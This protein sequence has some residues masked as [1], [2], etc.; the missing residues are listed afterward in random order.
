[1]VVDGHSLTLEIVAIPDEGTQVS[2][3]LE[4][5]LGDLDPALE[6]LQPDLVFRLDPS[7]VALECTHSGLHPVNLC[8]PP[9][10]VISSKPL[11]ED[12]ASVNTANPRPDP[13]SPA[14]TARKG[15]NRGDECL[16]PPRHVT[17][18]SRDSQSHIRAALLLARPLWPWSYVV[19]YLPRDQ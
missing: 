4:E 8:G 17:H 14:K 13:S 9:V 12:K 3:S 5:I 19:H 18:H 11:H 15:H 6:S 1:M 16:K 10:V 7:A 2:K